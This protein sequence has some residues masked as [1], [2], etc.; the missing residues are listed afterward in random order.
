[1]IDPAEWIKNYLHFVFLLSLACYRKNP[2]DQVTGHL[3]SLLVPLS[4]SKTS[5]F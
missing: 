2:K 4:G 1:M 3:A 5:L